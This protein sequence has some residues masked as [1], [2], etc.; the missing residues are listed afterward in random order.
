MMHPS[1]ADEIGEELT[2]K[3]RARLANGGTH[4][5]LELVSS[6]PET[7]AGTI[8]NLLAAAGEQLAAQVLQE[9]EL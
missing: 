2:I 7:S 3:V 5:S 4:V 1:L 8:L 9:G 6:K